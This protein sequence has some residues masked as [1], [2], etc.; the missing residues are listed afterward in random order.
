MRKLDSG[1]VSRS[2]D[3]FLKLPHVINIGKQFT[4]GGKDILTCFAHYMEIENFLSV[5]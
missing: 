4:Q 1:H 3:L 2:I 5:T